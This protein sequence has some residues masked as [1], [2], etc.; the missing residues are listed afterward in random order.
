MDSILEHFQ[1]IQWRYA[2]Q[3]A[4]A[5]AELET[6]IAKAGRRESWITYSDLVRGVHFHLPTLTEPQHS[7]DPAEWTELDRAIVGDF[8]GYLSM[9]SYAEGGFFSSALVVTKLDGK[10]GE[11][12]FSL[13][14]ELGLISSSKTDKAMY[15]WS[16]HVNMAHEYYRDP[17]L[18][19]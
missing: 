4:A 3:D 9:E 10:P 16:D 2:P 17:P 15:L 19:Q 11:G 12:F 1:R 6:R 5:K 7:I 8:L 18:R 14:K 13:L